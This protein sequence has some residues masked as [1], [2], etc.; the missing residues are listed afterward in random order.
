MLFSIRVEYSI[1]YIDLNFQDS[2]ITN[3]NYSGCSDDGYSIVVN[4]TTCG[5]NNPNGT[6]IASASN[7][8]DSTILVDLIFELAAIVEAGMPPNTL[9]SNSSLDLSTLNASISRGTSSGTWTTT[10]DGTFDN[11]GDFETATSY[12]PG[13]FEIA[14]G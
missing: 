12:T 7:G 2:I 8:C 13:P 1:V 14:I 6:E 10:G 5:V 3:I 4:V 11:S 9:C